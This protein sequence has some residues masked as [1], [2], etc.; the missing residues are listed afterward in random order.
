[1]TPSES[2]PSLER[3]RQYCEGVLAEF[4]EMAL[5][6][7]FAACDECQAAV[8]RMN[9]LLFTG[10]SASAHAA[11]AEAE[12]RREDILV[13]ALQHARRVYRDVAGALD[14][15]LHSSAALWGVTAVS[16]WG[17]EG[18]LPA[19]AAA[20]ASPLRITLGGESRAE[21][22]IREEFQAIE[23]SVPGTV[24][25]LAVLFRPATDPFV[26]VAAFLPSGDVSL[27]V[28]EDVPEGHYFLAISP[29]HFSP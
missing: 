27:A 20:V 25:A 3:L 8:R 18:L 23:V 16:R 15:W 11:A 10:F 1:M 13:S 7:H 26:R 5:E 22:E 17:D 21:L 28:F 19:H 9:A 2:H 24:R 14:E 29:Q 12:E 6:D 4:E